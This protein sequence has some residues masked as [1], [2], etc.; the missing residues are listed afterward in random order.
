[1]PERYQ[2][3]TLGDY[4]TRL[5]EKIKEWAASPMWSL[6][7]TGAVGTRK[8]SIAAAILRAAGGGYFATPQITVEKI[9]AFLDW[10]IKRVSTCKLLLLD[11]LA[12]YRATPHV[13][14]TLLG[15]L[16][17]RYDNFRKTIIT[18]N[19]S[20]AEIGQW[21][22]PRLADRLKEGLVMFSGKESRRVSGNQ[23]D[24]AQKAVGDYLAGQKP[25]H[26]A[27]PE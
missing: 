2:Q 18:S 20:L 12:S 8:T 15:I 16:G 7:L 4:D 3:W 13:H 6:Y 25:K 22:D 10:W 26:Q 5:V 1:M 21:L 23:K 24:G 11:D 17:A 27:P 9:R 19:A 14:D